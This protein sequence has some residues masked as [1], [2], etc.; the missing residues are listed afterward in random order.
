[1]LETIHRNEVREFSEFASGV[2]SSEKLI[3]I[4]TDQVCDR[5][6][7]SLEAVQEGIER[8]IILRVLEKTGGNQTEAA[9]LLGIKRTT[10]SYKIRKLNIPKS[11]SQRWGWR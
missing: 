10:L 11:R 7:E 8:R 4:L 5:I 2:L 3:E 1:M 9:K 6:I